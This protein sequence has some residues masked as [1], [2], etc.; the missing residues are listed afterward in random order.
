MSTVIPL[1][2]KFKGRLS[3]RCP[4]VKGH[5]KNRVNKPE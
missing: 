4:V 2:L 1:I 3:K 5:N